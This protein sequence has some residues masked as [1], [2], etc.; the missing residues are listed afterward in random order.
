MEENET[1]E[2]VCKGKGGIPTS[3]RFNFNKQATVE[4]WRLT[5]HITASGTASQASASTQLAR[6][7]GAA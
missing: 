4:G 1:W 3:Q 7:M 2:K 5:W 6:A